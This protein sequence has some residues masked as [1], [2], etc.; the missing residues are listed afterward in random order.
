MR[1]EDEVSLILYAHSL[2]GNLF[3]IRTLQL[4]RARALLSTS[5]VTKTGT[6]FVAANALISFYFAHDILRCSLVL[7]A[8]E[9]ITVVLLL[10]F[11]R[12]QIADLKT[13]V[14]LFLDRWILNL[15]LGSA[16]PTARDTAL[17]NQ[18]E[19][20]QTLLRPMFAT[21][22]ALSIKRA[23][24]LFTAPLLAEL[25]RIQTEPHSA[26][27]RLENLRNMLRKATDFRRKSGQATRQTHIQC[28][29]MVILLFALTLFT[30]HR[31]GWRR[32]SDLIVGAILLSLLGLIIMHFCARKTKWKI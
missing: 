21:Q 3:V 20:F 23:H 28:A 15:R 6:A 12:R 17:Q 30:L 10:C 22:N 32:S 19:S 27:A 4:F 25:E 13:E 5:T 8:F 26:L 14:P 1:S 11:E 7:M 24:L 9:T 31:Y 16:L 18:S 29:V 2:F